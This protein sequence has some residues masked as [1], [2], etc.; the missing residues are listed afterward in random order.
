MNKAVILGSSGF[1]GSRLANVLR[2]SFELY[3]ADI[4]PGPETQ[5]VDDLT[6]EKVWGELPEKVDLVINC[7]AVVG[8]R[9]NVPESDYF[10]INSYLPLRAGRYAE[11]AG[12]LYIH[13][14]TS[15]IYGFRE[16]LSTENTTPNPGD[17]YSLSKYL[18]ELS[19]IKLLNK[20]S[21]LVLRLN[22]PFGQSQKKGLIPGLIHKILN[23]FPVTLNTADGKP[24][25]SPIWIE[26]LVELI[27]CAWG[28]KLYGV[29]NCGGTEH[30]SILQ[31]SEI[32]GK[33]TCR[34]VLF[35]YIDKPCLDLMCNSEKLYNDCGYFLSYSLDHLLEEM[36]NQSL[37]GK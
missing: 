35:S 18:G 19:C 24:V 30:L 32:I 3:G 17:I 36:S 33:H 16:G 11:S 14:S 13:L 22:F 4:L 2:E 28:K 5:L 7:A 29:Y 10:R 20:D 9:I 23:G 21:L 12:A 25:I 15:G 31:I 37:P 6:N 26:D 34:K 8:Q 27:K 1:V